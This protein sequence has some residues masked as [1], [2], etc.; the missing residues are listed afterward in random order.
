MVLKL[1]LTFFQI[2]GT[3][4]NASRSINC[5]LQHFSYIYSLFSVIHCC[6][7]LEQHELLEES[8]LDEKTKLRGNSS[9]ANSGERGRK[10]M[11]ELLLQVVLLV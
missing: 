5:R 4:D 9:V 6:V 2:T 1:V 8:S 10:A 3:N 11:S 7:R